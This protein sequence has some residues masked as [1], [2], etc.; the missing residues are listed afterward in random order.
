MVKAVCLRVAI[1][2]ATDME[3]D[4]R[5]SYQRPHETSASWR[6]TGQ[7]GDRETH[8]LPGLPSSHAS[9]VTKLHEYHIS[10]GYITASSLCLAPETLASKLFC[11]GCSNGCH[12]SSLSHLPPPCSPTAQHDHISPT[13]NLV[14]QAG[15]DTLQQPLPH[16][17]RVPFPTAL[18]SSTLRPLAHLFVRC[19]PWSLF[20]TLWFPV[21]LILQ[22]PVHIT[23]SGMETT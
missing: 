16:L 14:P 21:L 7:A 9:T 12:L 6:G 15:P 1:S 3:Q 19:R 4:C 22:N 5:R 18:L 23:H 2:S 13:A 8:H 11:L 10:N 17:G 20:P